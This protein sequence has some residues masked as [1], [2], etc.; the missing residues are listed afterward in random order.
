[1]R[2]VLPGY[3][4]VRTGRTGYKGQGLSAQRAYRN[5]YARCA[6]NKE[7]V[8]RMGQILVLNENRLEREI[9]K[10]ILTEGLES[11]EVVL[12]PAE[13][14]AMELLR[15][16]SVDLLIA[17]VPKFDLRR[18][19]MM[20]Q[21]RQVSPDTPVL[22]TSSGIRADIAPHVWRLGLQDYLLKPCRPA[23][24]LAAVRALKRDVRTAPDGREDRRR[25]RYLK[26]LA[27]QMR[28]FCYK[29][30]TEIAKD[31]LDSLHKEIHN[32]SVIRFQ[33]LRFAGGLVQMGD[34][35]GSTVQMRLAGILERFRLRFGQQVQKYGAYLVL[36]KMLNVI[37]D[38]FDEDR[39]YQISSGQK[40]LNYIDRNIREGISLDQAADYAN[41]SSY[42][43][44]RFF[45]KI[46]GVNF[47]T[48]VTDC[49]IAVAREMLENTDM[50][51][52]SIACE[53]SYNEANYLSKVFKR[54]MGMTP[55]E[56]RELHCGAAACAKT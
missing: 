56:Y 53:L 46:T 52:I 35:L 50:P 4:Q 3:V 26:L 19:D 36:E 16:G 30:C 55:T 40:V 24:L 34:P 39:S 18:C 37:F 22:V 1:M 48:Y 25:E 21:A 10:S 47:I 5:P 7:G 28:A 9:T 2:K 20:A 33:V 29:K 12:A 38:V 42:Y 43:F 44:S 8:W 6:K 51:V 41:M 27:E 49:K 54:K 32:E 14:P 17:D 15:K 11:P 13:E 23:W 45:K 31:Y